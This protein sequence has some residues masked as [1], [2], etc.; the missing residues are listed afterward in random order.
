MET[1][2]FK[3][4]ADVLVMESPVQP[5]LVGNN[6][7]LSRCQ[8]NVIPV[9]PTKENCLPQSQGEQQEDLC[10]VETR[11]SESR[12]QAKELKVERCNVTSISAEELKEAQ[13]E[14]E[15]LRK[16]REDANRNA[17]S[18]TTANNS[19][20]R[21]IWKNGLLRREFKERDEVKIQLVVPK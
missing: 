3:G 7:F 9:Y 12:K 10:A 2:F 1:P 20:V 19:K 11:S 13:G 14:D 16:C 18:S 15:T 4:E 5:V 8:A 21:Y 6:R 17:K